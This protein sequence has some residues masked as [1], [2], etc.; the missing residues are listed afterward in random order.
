MKNYWIAYTAA[1]LSM[2]MVAAVSAGVFRAASAEDAP[3]MMVPVAQD[4]PANPPAPDQS[5]APSNAPAAAQAVDLTGQ[6][7]YSAKGHKIGTVSSMTTDAQGQQV[8]VVGVER[9]LGLGGKNVEFP[10]SS[11]VPRYS[12]GYST[13]LTADEIKNLPEYQAGGGN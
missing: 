8:A 5:A 10:L 11:L 12:G 6:A 13:T 7:I 4:Q 2:G 3:Q 9:F 1:A